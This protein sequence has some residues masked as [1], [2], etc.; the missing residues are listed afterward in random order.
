VSATLLAACEPLRRFPG[1][2]D[3]VFPARKRD[4]TKT[5][6]TSLFLP[7]GEVIYNVELGLRDGYG[8]GNPGAFRN[9]D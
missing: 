9:K 6:I 1:K 8:V 3:A 4:K 7:D 2:V 5:W